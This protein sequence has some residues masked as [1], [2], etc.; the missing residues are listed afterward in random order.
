ME[1]L[2]RAIEIRL[3]EKAGRHASAILI[4]MMMNGCVV[5]ELHEIPRPSLDG[6]LL[7]R[8]AAELETVASGAAT[9]AAFS[10]TDQIEDVAFNPPSTMEH[11]Q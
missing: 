8:I 11:A 4:D 3:G 1:A 10:H 7:V 6:G 9:S 5:L 2:R